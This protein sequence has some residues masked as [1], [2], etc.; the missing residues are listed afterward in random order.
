MAIVVNQIKMEDEDR[1]DVEY[2][3]FRTLQEGISA[4]T[5]LHRSYFTWHKGSFPTKMKKLSLIGKW[6]VEQ[7]FLDFI[8]LL[9]I[10]K[11]EYMIVGAHDPSYHDRLR[12]KSILDI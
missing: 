3:L 11:V 12:P 5:N 1:M 6:I 4:M 7:D 2:L 9:N 10:H 8:E